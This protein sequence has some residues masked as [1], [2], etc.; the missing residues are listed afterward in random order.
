MDESFFEKPKEVDTNIPEH[1]KILIQTLNSFRQDFFHIS[2]VDEK[3][4]TYEHQED[5]LNEYIKIRTEFQ[6]KLAR[7]INNKK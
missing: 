3:Y 1:W 6:S 7:L 5:I 2:C 4:H